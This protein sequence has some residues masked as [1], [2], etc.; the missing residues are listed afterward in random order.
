[1]SWSLPETISIITVALNSAKHIGKAIESVLAQDDGMLQYI[2]IDG[3]STDDT[4]AVVER[5]RP[6]LGNRLV[7]VSEKDSGLYDA[8]N[9]GIA[10]ATGDVIGI[11]NS[12]DQY[13]PGA[14]EAVKATLRTHD[15]DIVYGDVEVNGPDGPRLYK[16]SLNGIREIM[17][18]PHPGCFVT[19][20]A[21][22]RWG[23]FDTRYRFHA[24]YDLLLRCYLGGA[25]FAPMNRLVARFE[26]GGLSSGSFEKRRREH[27][28]IHRRQVGRAHALWVQAKIQSG[29][30]LSKARRTLGTALLGADRYER[31]RLRWRQ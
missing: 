19:R 9:K 11:L 5:Y 21:Y 27:Y 22:Q 6:R 23:V 12:D 17:S 29:V 26:T 20:A 1:V 8:M 16:G 13:L 10:R 31:V 7:V 14:I 25:R 28:D 30:A 24:D 3:A 2:V 15:V 4:V 18:I